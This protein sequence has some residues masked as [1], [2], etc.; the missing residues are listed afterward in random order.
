VP[1]RFESFD[2]TADD[3]EDLIDAM[4]PDNPELAAMLEAAAP[5]VSQGG[6]L[7]AFDTTT[8]GTG[9]ADNVNVIQQPALG[10][11]TSPALERQLVAGFESLGATVLNTEVIDLPVNE[12]LRIDYRLPLNLPDGTAIEASG[13]AVGLRAGQHA[14]NI[15]FTTGPGTGDEDFDVMLDSFRVAD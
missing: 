5:I 9:F 4:G 1:D 12:A 6:K 8:Y 14:W 3:I 13:R 2:L 10:D 7:I 15:T 11:P